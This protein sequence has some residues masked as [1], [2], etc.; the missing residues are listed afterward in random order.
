V[1][2][3]LAEMIRY[4]N[5]DRSA[6]H[7]KIKMTILPSLL[8]TTSPYFGTKASSSQRLLQETQGVKER[9]KRCRLSIVV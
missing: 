9:G 4:A 6:P 2:I 1:S 8:I 3:D 7:T 5:I